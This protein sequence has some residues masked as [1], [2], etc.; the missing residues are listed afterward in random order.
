MQKQIKLKDYVLIPE[1][2]Y[3]N[4]RPE[5][6]DLRKK[7]KLD[8]ADK[9]KDKVEFYI[10]S[11]LIGM[12]ISFFLGLF[13]PTISKYGLKDFENRYVFTY[14]DDQVKKLFEKD[15]EYGKKAALRE[16]NPS[17]LILKLQGR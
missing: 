11:G 16:T 14:E 9:Q 8:I 12:N 17:D 5:G 2:K 10:N 3:F 15:F 4:G 6:Q 7:L 1:Q 13:S